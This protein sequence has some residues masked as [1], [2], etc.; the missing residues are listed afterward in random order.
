M[1]L[2]THF[3]VPYIIL[4]ALKSRN[5]LAGAFG[6]IAP[7]FDTIF[8]AWIGILAPQFFI[9]SHRGITHS[10]IFGLVTSTIFLYVV[11]K[12]NYSNRIFWS[13]NPFIPWLSYN[14]RNSF[15]L[16]IFN[17]KVRCRNISG[18]GCVHDHNCSHSTCYS[19]S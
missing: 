19:L 11:Y 14:F 13:F 8:V 3:L 2:F 5:K 6:G 15:I 12:N 4:L 18:P 17:Y 9:F 16:S 10:F 7:D 1:D